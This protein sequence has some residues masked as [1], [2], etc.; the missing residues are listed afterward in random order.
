MES[1]FRKNYSMSGHIR[2][3]IDKSF[4][5]MK[6]QVST[7]ALCFWYDEQRDP[8]L[9]RHTRGSACEKE[10]VKPS[11]CLIGEENND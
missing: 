7:T 10:T 5:I 2:H 11:A 1:S 3:S 4:Y 6:T 8:G 9:I